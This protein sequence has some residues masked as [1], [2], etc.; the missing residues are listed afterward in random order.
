MI[1]DVEAQ[2]ADIGLEWRL[3]RQFGHIHLIRDPCRA[4]RIGQL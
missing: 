4:R 3:L 2:I 1:S